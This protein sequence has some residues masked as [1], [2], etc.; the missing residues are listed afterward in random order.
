MP[1]IVGFGVAARLA[2]TDRYAQHIARLRDRLECGV[3]AVAEAYLSTLR[4]LNSAGLYARDEETAKKEGI[5]TLLR[6]S[7]TC[8]DPEVVE[9]FITMLEPLALL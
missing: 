3:V 6:G 8:F 4:R 1:G 2:L 7:G 9:K 5:A